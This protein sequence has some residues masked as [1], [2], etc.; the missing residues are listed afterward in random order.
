MKKADFTEYIITDERFEKGFEGYKFIMLS[1]LHSNEYGLD[2]HEVNRTIKKYAPD[3]I[4]ISGDMFNRK[5][6]EDIREVLRFISVLAKH[7]AVFYALGNHEYSLKMGENKYREKYEYIYV[8]LSE[9]GVC[10]LQDETVYL[11]KK[12]NKIALSGVEIDSVFYKFKHPVMGNGLVDK[13]LGAVD[14]SVYNI[15]LAHNPEYFVNY[16][17]WGADLVLAGHIHGGI[18][19]LP[20]IGGVVST[21]RKILP[22]FDSGMYK[23]RK[24]KKMIIGRGLGAHTIKVRINNRPEIV[25]VKILAKN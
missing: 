25:A 13:H 17:K 23:S 2:L 4:L 7:Y 19:R 6:D 16:A 14:N 9:A 20:Y 1:D 5:P 18:I 24:G 8:M 10:F 22:H 3:A 15:L 11:E 12:G 21:T